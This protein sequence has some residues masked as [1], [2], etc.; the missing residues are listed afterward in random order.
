MPKLYKVEVNHVYY[1][2][3]ESKGEAEGYWKDACMDV[4]YDIADAVEV[5][6]KEFPEWE[7]S[8]LVYGGEEDTTLDEARAMMGLPTVREITKSYVDKWS[9]K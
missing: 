2:L 9:V 4:M 3:A 7:G 8:D 5:R 1:A 6:E